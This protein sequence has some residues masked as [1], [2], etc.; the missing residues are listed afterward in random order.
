M[1]PAKKGDEKKKGHSAINTVVTQECTISIH[2]HI[3]GVGLKK[4]IP[5]ALKEIQKFAMKKIKTLDVYIVSG[6]TKLSGPK[7]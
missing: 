7:K 5:Q 4:C 6:S 3:H 1:A 2:K